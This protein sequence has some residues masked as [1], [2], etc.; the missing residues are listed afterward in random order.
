MP[1]SSE[2]HSRFASTI[3][4]MLEAQC[5]VFFAL[6]VVVNAVDSARMLVEADVVEAFETCTRN[7]F[8]PM[9]RNQKVL[10]PSHP[11]LLAL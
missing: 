1:V 9:I 4:D 3:V 7:R 5:L 11:Q 8:D 2:L 6:V 10:L